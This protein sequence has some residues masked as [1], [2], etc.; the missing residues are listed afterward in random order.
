MAV[1]AKDVKELRRISGAGMMDCKKA[2]E[3]TEGS[4]DDALKLLRELGIKVASKRAGRLASEGLVHSY[5]HGVGKLGVLVE[6]NCETDFVARTDDFKGFCKLLAMHV[7]ACDPQFVSRD[8]IPEVTVNEERD[9]LR[10]QLVDSGKPDNIV[11]KIITG[12]LEKYYSEV[13]LL[14]QEWIHDSSLGSVN[15][16]VTDLIGKI[17]EN[18]VVN[19]FT[20]FEIGS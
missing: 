15:D 1:D 14:D 12:R 9:I 16:V 13:C 7:A 6:V 2:L 18:I 19:R 3:E 11:E 10:K 8:A 17:G 5:I 20:R 4:I